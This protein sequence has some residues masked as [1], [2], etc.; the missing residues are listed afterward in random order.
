MW[1]RRQ[2]DDGSETYL[3]QGGGSEFAARKIEW[4]TNVD[5]EIRRGTTS[6]ARTGLKLR[7]TD[8]TAVYISVD[9]GTTVVCSTTAF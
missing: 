9:T 4:D 2:D 5:A 8:G 7:R 1:V 6:T 3:A